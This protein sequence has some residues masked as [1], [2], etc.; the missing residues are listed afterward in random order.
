MMIHGINAPPLFY[1]FPFLYKK[2]RTVYS[3][4]NASN[5]RKSTMVA[6]VFIGYVWVRSFCYDWFRFD[7]VLSLQ[8]SFPTVCKDQEDI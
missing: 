7:F 5:S 3:N 1:G 8:V 6:L 4:I 2:N